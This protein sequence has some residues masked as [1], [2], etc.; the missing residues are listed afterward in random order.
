MISVF[1]VLQGSAEALIRWGRKIY[2]PPIARHNKTF[3]PKIIKIQQRLLELQWK[4]SGVFFIETQCTWCTCRIIWF[5]YLATSS[6]RCQCVII[7]CTIYASAVLGL[8]VA[9]CLCLSVCVCQKSEFYRNGWT[10]Q[11]GF[12][13]TAASFRP[14][15]YNEIRESPRIWVLPS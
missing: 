5:K 1:L 12:F 13:G 11:A 9:R 6:S 7:T 3:L 8:A 4:T 15:C 14:L 2:H 10:D